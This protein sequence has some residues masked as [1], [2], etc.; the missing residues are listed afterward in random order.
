MT[1]LSDVRAVPF[2]I[3][4][5]SLVLAPGAESNVTPTISTSSPTIVSAGAAV[6]VVMRAWLAT[7]LAGFGA[8]KEP[9]NWAFSA[10]RIVAPT[11]AA[12]RTAWR[13]SPAAT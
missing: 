4:I 11:G 8:V 6:D 9:E 10:S 1:S 13:F 2:L 7:I 3:A 12:F 5:R